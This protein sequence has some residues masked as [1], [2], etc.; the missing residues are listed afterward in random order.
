MVDLD[1]TLKLFLDRAGISASED[2]KT[3]ILS[4]L[5]AY[6][7]LIKDFL[8][9]EEFAALAKEVIDAKR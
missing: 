9:D 2:Q 7:G 5:K 3:R 8:S 1:L 4:R 6:S